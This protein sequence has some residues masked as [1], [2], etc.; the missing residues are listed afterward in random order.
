MAKCER[1]NRRKIMNRY[2]G[3]ELCDRCILSLESKAIKEF[4]R[5]FFDENGQRVR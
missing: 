5:R 2:Q 1:C 3:M 4:A